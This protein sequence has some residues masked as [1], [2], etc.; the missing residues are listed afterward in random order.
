[1]NKIAYSFFLVI[2]FIA[3]SDNISDPPNPVVTDPE[4]P[5]IDEQ[6]SLQDLQDDMLNLGFKTFFQINSDTPEDENILISPLSIETALYMAANGAEAETL[7]E[8]RAALEMGSFYPTGVNEKYK[9]LIETI[10]ADASDKTY[11]NSAQAAFY[12]PGLFDIDETFK[13]NLENFYD[14]DVY[15]DKFNLEAINGWA[16]EK[17]NGR[18]PK[19][20]DKI[21]EEEFMFVMN[22]LYFLG[23]WEK[24]F[25]EES[26][27]DGNFNFVNNQRPT[28]RMMNQDSGL[29]HYIGVDLKA[30]DL[31]FV[32]S[33]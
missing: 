19:V 30:V 16:N 14:A 29:P 3:C 7:D 27:I 18:I 6:G 33:K 31:K 25:A 26:T 12:N 10:N 8:I 21:K 11:L 5:S 4:E 15:D 28:V 17:T 13:S 9:A 1:M 24:P 2:L 32:E 23:D 22:A 20:L